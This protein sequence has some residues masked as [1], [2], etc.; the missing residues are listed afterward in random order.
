MAASLQSLESPR[1]FVIDPVEAEYWVMP[2]MFPSATH[3]VI[4]VPEESAIAQQAAKANTAFLPK[5]ITAANPV[6][7]PST[8]T[9]LQP[10]CLQIK[11][12]GADTVVPAMNPDQVA[13]LIETCNQIGLTNV[14]WAITTFEIT[15]Q[16]VQTLSSLRARNLIVL[17]LGGGI[18][19][20]QFAADLAK[21]GP[22][23]GGIT[24][25]LAEPAINAWLAV[26]LLPQVVAGAG[27]LDPSKIIARLNQQRAFSTMGASAPINFTATPVAQIPRLKTCQVPRPR[28]LVHSRPVAGR[29]SLGPTDP[30]DPHHRPAGVPGAASRITRGARRNPAHSVGLPSTRTERTTPASLVN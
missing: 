1:V 25:T 12:S 22:G 8:A 7:I 28:L 30:V 3:K 6:T 29:P 24:N 20:Q 13:T 19:E 16:A 15:P 14:L 4:Y 17:G 9:S 11:A 21:Y 18:V 26:R 2:Q 23:V 5:T 10:Y 27:S